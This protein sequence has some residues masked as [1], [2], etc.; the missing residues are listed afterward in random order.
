MS[1]RLSTLTMEEKRQLALL[2]REALEEHDGSQE[3]DEALM[4]RLRA[5]AAGLK[6]PISA[7]DMDLARS[8]YR[9]CE[10]QARV[11]SVVNYLIEM[12]R[13]HDLMQDMDSVADAVRQASNLLGFDLSDDLVAQACDLVLA[14]QDEIRRQD[15]GQGV[16]A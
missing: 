1:D 3:T 2:V 5:V 12:G 13:Q 6:L 9:A 4:A 10:A 7:S 8:E 15:E 16:G 14:E 11:R